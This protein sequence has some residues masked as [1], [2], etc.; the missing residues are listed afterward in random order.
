MNVDSI[1]TPVRFTGF[2][3]KNLADLIFSS[4]N[5]RDLLCSV[6]H[7]GT[8]WSLYFYLPIDILV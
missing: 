2:N 6:I 5:I 4:E 8:D 7:D 3:Q 1:G